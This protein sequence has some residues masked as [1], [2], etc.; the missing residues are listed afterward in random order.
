VSK[1][2]KRYGEA[3]FYFIAG[4]VGLMVVL[5]SVL[6]AQDH[7]GRESPQATS[8]MAPAQPGSASGQTSAEAPQTRTRGS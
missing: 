8:F 6:F 1:G 7:A 2:W 5:W 4:S 3:R